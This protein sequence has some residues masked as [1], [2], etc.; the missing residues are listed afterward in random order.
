MSS[1]PETR[2]KFEMCFLELV[3]RK[4]AITIGIVVEVTDTEA[5]MKWA[6]KGKPWQLIWNYGENIVSSKKFGCE[7]AEN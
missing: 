2:V 5:K 4:S 1:V 7:K 6:R 3:T